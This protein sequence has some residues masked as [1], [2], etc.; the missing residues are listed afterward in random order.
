MRGR[1]GARFCR[2]P[3]VGSLSFAKS[4][5][6]NKISRRERR[7]TYTPPTTSHNEG[8]KYVLTL[9]IFLSCTDSNCRAKVQART[10]A[11]EEQDRKGISG[12]AAQSKE[13]SQEGRRIAQTSRMQAHMISEPRMAIEGEE[14]PWHSQPVPVQGQD[15]RRSGGDTPSQRRG[16]CSAS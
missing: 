6:S 16:E 3:P 10:C 4:S 2:S 15:S 1:W 14:G 7:D 13:S 5:T 12:E 9:Y 11:I 8:R